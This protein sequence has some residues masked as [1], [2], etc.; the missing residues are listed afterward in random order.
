[1]PN[2]ILDAQ[3]ELQLDLARTSSSIEKDVLVLLVAM[4]KELVAKI[5]AGDF[6][7]ISRA[8]IDQQLRQ[9]SGLISEYYDKAATIV[10]EASPAIAEVTALATKQSLAVGATV[11][12]MPSKAMLEAIASQSVVQ[13]AAQGAWWAKQSADTAFKYG[14]AVRQ[15]LVAG[16][17]NQ[18]IIARVRSFMDVSRRSAAALVQTSVATVANDSR[19][20]VYAA[21]DDIIKRYRAVATLDSHTC[22]T[23]A[24][25]DGLEWQKDG[26]AIGHK[27]SLPRYPLHMNC[28]CLT[29]PVIFDGPQGG[30]RASA[31]GPIAASTSFDDWLKR[32]SPEKIE[33]VLGKGRADLYQS[34][35]LTLTDLVSGR[36]KPLSLKALQHKYA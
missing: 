10:S 15:G 4:Q 6:T 3:I 35:K 17:T 31:D 16:E 7:A 20:A 32:Q 13:G 34:G 23:C 11:A 2:K 28:R 29:I 14:Q 36:G 19:F 30:Q 1:M 18:Q 24:P 9:V 25:L 26:A 5:A 33:E 21:N 12:A 8:R 27:F 22:L